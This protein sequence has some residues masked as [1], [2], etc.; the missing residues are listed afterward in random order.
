[1]TDWQDS[2]R[3]ENLVT[4]DRSDRYD[5]DKISNV[6]ADD[7]HSNCSLLDALQSRWRL[8]L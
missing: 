8:S 2:T 3:S 4:E 7:D 1:V 5:N 6:S